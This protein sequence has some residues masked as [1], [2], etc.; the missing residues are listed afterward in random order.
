MQ[1]WMSILIGV[2]AGAGCAVFVIC[3]YVFWCKPQHPEYSAEDV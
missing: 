1:A 2:G 3:V